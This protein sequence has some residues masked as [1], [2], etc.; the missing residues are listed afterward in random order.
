MKKYRL[1]ENM[2]KALCREPQ[3]RNAHDY[4]DT[5]VQNLC[6]TI[7]PSGAASWCLR[8][9]ADG[10]QR[11]LTLGRFPGVS[12]EAA[13]KAARKFLGE[14]AEGRD[15]AAEKRAR[16][17]RDIST[18]T[19]PAMAETFIRR[20]AMV[21]NRGWRA[22]ARVLGLRLSKI[23]ARQIANPRPGD[24]PPAFI[25]IPD[26][27]A[28]RWARKLARDITRADVAAAVNDL[29]PTFPSAACCRLAQLKSAFN[30]LV[31]NGF[32]D[33]HPCEVIPPPAAHVAR[34]R[35]LTDDEITSL[36]AASETLRAPFRQ[37]V[38]V[39][40]LV[41][42]RRTEVARMEWSELAGDAWIIPGIKAKN[43]DEHT[44]PLSALVLAELQTL[45]RLGRYVFTS[46]PKGLTAISCFSDIKEDIDAVM[47]ADDGW[48]LH[49]LRRTAASGMGKLGV[50]PHVIE[51]VLNHRSGVISGI[52]RVYNR[53]PYAP[54]KRAALDA[55]ANHVARVVR[56]EKESAPAPS[57]ILTFA[58]A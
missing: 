1:S 27:L 32:L 5:Q 58:T 8:Y 35:V 31:A 46:S 15:P 57:N 30:W 34:D 21:K 37:Y 36:W 55:W 39:L 6:V 9:R 53:N 22:Q 42:Q 43:G 12:V 38:R 13:R 49:D 45:P 50:Q 2:L 33:A 47:S 3:H 26:S 25:A 28:T 51:A 16:R 20:H 44:V 29:M 18:E 17:Q 52:A 10:R 24:P 14:I 56:G 54:E 48:T 7:R 4:F 40:L 41:G 11:R 19:Y 23:S